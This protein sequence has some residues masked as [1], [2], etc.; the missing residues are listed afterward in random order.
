MSS[1]VI[2]ELPEI[3]GE[4]GKITVTYLANGTA[5]IGLDPAAVGDGSGDMLKAVY[6]INDNNVVDSADSVPWAGITDVPTTFTPSSHNHDDIYY[7]DDEVDTLL[8]GYALATHDHDSDYSAAGHAHD[9]APLVAGTTNQVVVTDDTDG[10]ITLSLPQSI[11]SAATPT[12]AALTTTGDMFPVST[13]WGLHSRIIYPIT[14]TI[15]SHFPTSAVPASHTWQGSPFVTPGVVT[16]RQSDY[17]QVQQLS[18]TPNRYF[19][20]KSVSNAGASW[21]NKSLVGR[22]GVGQNGRMGLRHDDGTDDNYAEVFVNGSA[23][24]GTCTVTFR[25]R[26]GGGTA[27]QASANFTMPVTDFFVL[28]LLMVYT[29]VYY[30]AAYLCS[31]AN[32][33][34]SITGFNTDGGGWGGAFP[35]AG[36]AGIIFENTGASNPVFC[37]WYVTEF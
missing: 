16:V 34:M 4:P 9:I 23:N 2:T 14:S 20:A 35:A 31:E 6:D 32:R 1:Q 18:S 36:R 11:H 33:N 13:L 22:F 12:F 29:S 10:T 30:S 17:L 24:D 15:T 28:R 27:T 26:V 19:L 5:V 3:V 25:S 7:T 37:D 21:Q 8:I